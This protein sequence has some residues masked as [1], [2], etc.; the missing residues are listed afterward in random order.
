MLKT[1]KYFN[2]FLFDRSKCKNALY[3]QIC[4]I[5]L[6]YYRYSVE[7]GVAVMSWPEAICVNFLM[8][9]FVV[10]LIRYLFIFF[11]YYLVKFIVILFEF[12]KF[13]NSKNT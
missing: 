5:Y 3:N 1:K 10:G 7:I 13:Y 8:F 4:A 12:Y 11:S 6:L 9:L 2:D